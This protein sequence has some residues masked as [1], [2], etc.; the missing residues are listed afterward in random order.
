MVHKS[1]AVVC[2]LLV[3]ATACGSGDRTSTPST[4]E[5]VRATATTPPASDVEGVIDVGGRSRTYRVHIPADAP[6]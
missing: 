5:A 1:A 6:D 2:L 3:L 4:T